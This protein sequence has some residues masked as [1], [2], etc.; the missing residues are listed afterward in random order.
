MFGYSEGDLPMVA[1]PFAWVRAGRWAS[2][3]LSFSA[4][5]PRGETN[6]DVLSRTGGPAVR[7]L[8]RQAWVR[9]R[10]WAS[11]ELA[12]WHWST[13]LPAAYMCCQQSPFCCQLNNIYIYIYI[14]MYTYIERDMCIYR[15]PSSLV[16]QTGV[17]QPFVRSA[18]RIYTISICIL[19]VYIYIYIY[20]ERERD[21]LWM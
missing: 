4:R 16:F 7:T 14:Y 2:C 19:W 18:T 3:E 15:E 13:R 1:N 6:H 12:L 8:G 21:I 5:R 9:A 17:A 20:I 10:R 11:C